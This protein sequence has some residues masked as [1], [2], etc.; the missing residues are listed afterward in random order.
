MDRVKNNKYPESP[1]TFE[2][3]R[4]NFAKPEIM[5]KYGYNLDVSDTLYIDTI[6]ND[7]YGFSLFASL[8]TINIL[9]LH[10]ETKKRKYLIDGTFSCV[11]KLYYQLL[12][13]SIEFKNDVSIVRL[14]QTEC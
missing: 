7:E 2:E 6:I 9:R 3:I 5:T 13:I 1:K 12:I 4:A 8:S 14:L 11:P 10:I